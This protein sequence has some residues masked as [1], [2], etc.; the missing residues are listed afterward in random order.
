VIVHLGNK[1][2]KL[3]RYPV[4]V[5]VSRLV[6]GSVLVVSGVL[7]PLTLG[8]TVA[9]ISEYVYVGS[10]HFLPTCVILLSSIELFLGINILVKNKSA[11]KFSLF[12]SLLMLSVFIGVD[13]Y[14]LLAFPDSSACGCFGAFK[15][16]SSPINSIIKTAVLTSISL[17]LLNTVVKKSYVLSLFAAPLIISCIIIGQLF[18][19]INNGSFHAYTRIQAYP[20]RISDEYYG[21]SSE[22][23]GGSPILSKVLSVF[24]GAT[25][26]KIVDG[27]IH[28]IVGK[29]TNEI[30]GYV[31][32]V[33][34]PIGRKRSSFMGISV[35]Y[36]DV[37]EILKIEFTIP[38]RVYST[39]HVLRFSSEI[40]RT[41]EWGFIEAAKLN[42]GQGLS[43]IEIILVD[44]IN[45]ATYHLRRN[46]NTGIEE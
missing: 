29:G 1:G 7:K 18:M 16:L 43:E 40:I 21:V 30:I 35:M 4:S 27:P 34:A 36:S 22:M 26:I 13:I 15:F 9:V 10:I 14:R 8:E 38:E 41:Q 45:N 25:S 11:Y 44:I 39:D 32:S 3:G 46:A 17:Y 31:Y 33:N 42:G 6:L 2:V 12:A 24:P 23:F 5:N 37:F 28:Q 19:M 20:T